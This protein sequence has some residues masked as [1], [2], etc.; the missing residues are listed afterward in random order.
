MNHLVRHWEEGEEAE[1]EEEWRPKPLQVREISSSRNVQK[2]SSSAICG[3]KYNWS[4][5]FQGRLLDDV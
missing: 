4:R 3:R 5:V 2:S 1:K